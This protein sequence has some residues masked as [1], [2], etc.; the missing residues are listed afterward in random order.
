MQRG[1]AGRQVEVVDGGTDRLGDPGAGAV[2]ELQQGPVAQRQRAG[3]GAVRAGGLQQGD[4]LGD[5]EGLRQ[6]AGRCR[7]AYVAA[8]VVADD[9]LA[10]GEAVQPAYGAG[11]PGGGGRRQRRVVGVALAQPG[12][13][14]GDLRG[15]D[16]GEVV[17]AVGRERVE[18]AV[19]VPPVRGEGVRRQSAF[20]GQVVEVGADRTPQGRRRRW[21][22]TGL[23]GRG[24]RRQASTSASGRVA[25]PCASATGP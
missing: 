11:G 23:R 4:D 13:V 19:Q 3:V 16:R 7:R 1:G 25:M 20:D 22:V 5:V 8:G 21:P 17:D 6:P 2:Q 10:D 15:P 9:A 14:R 24:R 18:V 12:D